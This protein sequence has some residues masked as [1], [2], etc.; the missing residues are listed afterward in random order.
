MGVGMLGDEIV[1]PTGNLNRCPKP[2][3]EG[4][5]N[6]V[7]QNY[8]YFVRCIR[9]GARSKDR[10]KGEE[11]VALWNENISLEAKLKSQ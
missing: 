6:L 7:M 5:G 1:L 3:C 2:D 8:L 11:A 9:C 4:Y 10:N